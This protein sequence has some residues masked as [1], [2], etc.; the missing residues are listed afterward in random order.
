MRSSLGRGLAL[1]CVE[2][3]H[4]LG[5][6]KKDV[7]A[8][9]GLIE[10][11]KAEARHGLACCQLGR[12]AVAGHDRIAAICISGTGVR[13]KDGHARNHQRLRQPLH[14]GVQQPPEIGL[15]TES[16]AK[17]DQRLAIVIPL[18][19]KHAVHP[20]LNGALERFEQLRR[21]DDRSDQ[22]PY[23]RTGKKAGMHQLRRHRYRSQVQT[24]QRSRGQSVGD[25]A[26]ED[27]V[28]IHQAVAN[29]RPAKS[30]RQK[31]EANARK[32]DQQAGDGYARKIG[33][34]V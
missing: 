31:D 26:L 4:L 24:N 18:M 30:K 8:G 32:F 27:E 12:Q 6:L 14:D 25:A 1:L 16:T 23:A 7:R 13:E 21:N 20:V 3:Q 9:I 19:I 17:G 11:E 22:A 15:R 29:D 33:N 28:D 5:I 34:D 10:V 2:V